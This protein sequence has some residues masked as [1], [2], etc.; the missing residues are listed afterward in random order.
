MLA[1]NIVKF[2][3]RVISG[4][5]IKFKLIY[6]AELCSTLR[7]SLLLRKLVKVKF[8]GFDWIYRWK[9]S[10]AVSSTYFYNP[11]FNNS[12]LDLFFF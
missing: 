11:C 9:N 2:I 6:L 1:K 7:A 5:F 3:L 10:A 4:K 12:D 8:D